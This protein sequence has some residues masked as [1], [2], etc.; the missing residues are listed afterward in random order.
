MSCSFPR[1]DWARPCRS[2]IC[3]LLLMLLF[4][5]LCSIAVGFTTEVP[6]CRY[7][8]GFAGEFGDHF[9]IPIET[10]PADGESIILVARTFPADLGTLLE[11]WL[12]I[13]ATY[14]LPEGAL[15]SR[16]SDNSG[17]LELSNV[18]AG[19]DIEVR[20]I[21]VRPDGPVPFRFLSF[22]ANRAVCHV[23]V[24]PDDTFLAPVPHRLAGTLKTV[25]MYF[26]T[27][28]PPD[29]SGATI[30]IVSDGRMDRPYEV[31]NKEGVWQK[32]AANDIIQPRADRTIPF[33]FTPASNDAGSTFCF[34]EVSVS[35]ASNQGGTSALTT[36]V[37]PGRGGKPN[38]PTLGGLPTSTAATSTTMDLMRRLLM[39]ALICFGVWQVAWAVYNYHVLGKRDLMEIVPCAE[40]VVAGAR[41]VQLAASRGL[42]VSHRRTDGYNPVQSMNDPYA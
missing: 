42:G 11:R 26:M 25:T 20:V 33:S 34:T 30:R 24:S 23:T 36:T 27:V 32:H 17:V 35:Y 31:L 8:H 15:V 22:F 19:T 41:G 10:A 14:H 13:N 12:Y 16:M 6:L 7:K 5:P 28:L 40:T 29:R 21:R 37:Q 3:A 1:P 38:A 39:I 4:T 18:A 2:V 9:S